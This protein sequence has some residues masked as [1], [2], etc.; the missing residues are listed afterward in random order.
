MLLLL[1]SAPAPSSAPAPTPDPAPSPAPAPV[2]APAPTPTPTLA[3]AP[4]RAGFKLQLCGLFCFVFSTK[5][6]F[7]LIGFS[8]FGMGRILSGNN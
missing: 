1:F 6:N 8:K 3:P 5:N 4:N 7:Y 2:P